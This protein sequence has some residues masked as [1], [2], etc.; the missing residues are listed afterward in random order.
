MKITWKTAV[1]SIVV[2]AVSVV[3]GCTTKV[4]GTPTPADPSGAGSG[5]SSEAEWA[6]E[7]ATEM[8]KLREV[9]PCTLLDRE[10][11]AAV[12]E[13]TAGIHLPGSHLS[14]CRVDT[15]IDEHTPSWS[16][17]VE[18]GTLF[19]AKKANAREEKIN[20]EQYFVTSDG[21]GCTYTRMVTD[22]IAVDLRVTVPITQ[23]DGDACEIAKSYLTQAGTSFTNMGRRDQHLTEPQLPLA[24]HDPCEAVAE[25]AKAM[26]TKAIA[27]PIKPYL[28]AIE[29]PEG[30]ENSPLAGQNLSIAY[31]FTTDPREN[32]PEDADTG[33][34]APPPGTEGLGELTAVTIAGHSG[35]QFDGAG[36]VGCGVDLVLNDE[37]TLRDDTLTM[38]QVVSVLSNDCEVSKTVA[39]AVITK[40]DP[41]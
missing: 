38:V 4:A 29:P 23:A 39:E 15:D 13:A 40:L 22:I 41:A 8:A 33:G 25:V 20:D 17:S 1:L 2:A 36:D 37:T 16:F 35:S 5:A 12:A 3:G 18:V 7:M 11:I 24:T 10:I 34:G 31:E 21:G 6:K 19:D 26:D 14:E 32:L 9:D 30:T 27:V 28:C